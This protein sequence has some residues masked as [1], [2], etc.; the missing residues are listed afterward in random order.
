M[1]MGVGG[2]EGRFLPSLG[3]SS[4]GFLGDVDMVCRVGLSW[5]DGWRLGVW[6]V[7]CWSDADYFTSSVGVGYPVF[8][9]RVYQVWI[10]CRGLGTLCWM[11]GWMMHFSRLSLE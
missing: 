1:R 9:S 5:V 8:L 3:W 11:D 6:F 7:V 4:S 10:P 2:S